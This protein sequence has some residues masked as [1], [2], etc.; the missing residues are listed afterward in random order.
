[1]LYYVPRF[2]DSTINLSYLPTLEKHFKNACAIS[3]AFFPPLATE[4]SDWRPKAEPTISQLQKSNDLAEKV[5]SKNWLTRKANWQNVDEDLLPSFP[6]LT[7]EDL[8]LLTLGSYQL[9][10]AKEYA[11]QHLKRKT[12]Y[13]I[14]IHIEDGTN[15][16]RAKIGSRMSKRT[17]HTGWIEFTLFA[18]GISSIEGFCCTCK[19]GA[20]VVGMCSH[21]CCVIWYLSYARHQGYTP[22]SYSLANNI[23]NAADIIIESGSQALTLTLPYT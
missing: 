11:N 13:E 20:R 14:Q 15:I 6:R 17:N 18:T 9:E 3:N 5:Q 10:L 21:L 16:V 19:V 23:L 2:F 4:N 8:K 1:L 22:R 12:P 7:Q